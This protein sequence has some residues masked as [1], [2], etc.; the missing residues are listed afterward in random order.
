MVSHEVD[1]ASKSR[2][3]N[4][5]GGGEVLA[6]GQARLHLHHPHVDPSV[7]FTCSGDCLG[8]SSRQLVICLMSNVAIL[9]VRTFFTDPSRESLSNLFVCAR[10]MN[11]RWGSNHSCDYWLACYRVVYTLK[12][13]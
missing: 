4:R 2:R 7:S 9:G 5:K 10:K 13:I 12:K 8:Y 11:A 6:H 1:G 3:R